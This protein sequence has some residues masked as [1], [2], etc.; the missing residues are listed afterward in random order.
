MLVI[1]DMY[2]TANVLG[3]KKTIKGLTS[4][5]NGLEEG[6]GEREEEGSK[7]KNFGE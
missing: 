1:K 6:G 5:G 3:K 4:P 2:I 7:S